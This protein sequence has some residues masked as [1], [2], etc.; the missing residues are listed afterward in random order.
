MPVAGRDYGAPKRPSVAQLRR[1]GGP[2]LAG[3]ARAAV[4]AVRRWTGVD[5][6][7]ALRAPRGARE[8]MVAGAQRTLGAPERHASVARQRRPGDVVGPVRARVAA[9]A[10]AA[11]AARRHRGDRRGAVVGTAAGAMVPG[12]VWPAARRLGGRRRDRGC[13]PQ[14]LGMADAGGARAQAA[15]RATQR[16]EPDE[17]GPAGGRG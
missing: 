15:V 3:G 11:G 10:L 5:F 2:G 12:A 14:R 13:A 17:P 9:T 1:A 16:C 6:R 8:R 4:A 7:I